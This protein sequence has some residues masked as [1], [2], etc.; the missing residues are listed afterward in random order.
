NL[1]PTLIRSGCDRTSRGR[2][3]SRQGFDVA[4]YALEDVRVRLLL[5]ARQLVPIS[6]VRPLRIGKMLE[7]LCDPAERDEAT[8][9]IATKFY[10]PTLCCFQEFSNLIVNGRSAILLPLRSLVP[11]SDVSRLGL[12][13]VML[14]HPGDPGVSEYSA[15]VE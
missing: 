15:S 6:D 10:G 4:L 1:A 14:Y 11:W 7:D 9:L 13:R 3:R 8:L 12:A 5:P 2:T